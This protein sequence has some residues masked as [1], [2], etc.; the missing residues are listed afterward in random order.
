MDNVTALI[1]QM[2]GQ[3][4]THDLDV[5]PIKPP[6]APQVRRGEF[7][8]QSTIVKAN[9][10]SIPIWLPMHNTKGMCNVHSNQCKSSSK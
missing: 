10:Q 6:W 3:G 1:L 5:A 9:S 8:V 7:S 2:V 4:K